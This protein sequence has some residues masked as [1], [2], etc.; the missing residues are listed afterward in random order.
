M[1][2]EGGKDNSSAL[3]NEYMPFKILDMQTT[4]HDLWVMLLQ[5]WRPIFTLLQISECPLQIRGQISSMPPKSHILIHDC[6]IKNSHYV[7]YPFLCLV[8]EIVVKIKKDLETI[9]LTSLWWLV[10]G[11]CLLSSL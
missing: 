7:L 6:H 11:F 1:A 4:K 10:V 8:L 3:L 2:V 5:I 9:V